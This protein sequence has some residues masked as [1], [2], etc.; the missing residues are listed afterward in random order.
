[1]CVNNSKIF[2]LS[3]HTLQTANSLKFTTNENKKQQQNNKIKKKQFS[4][5]VITLCVTS[6]EVGLEC[7]EK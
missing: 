4:L 2:I 7:A 5:S 1:M 6:I 3:Y